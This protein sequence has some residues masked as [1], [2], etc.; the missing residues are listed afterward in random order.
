MFNHVESYPMPKQRRVNDSTQMK[1]EIPYVPGDSVTPRL[2]AAKTAG[3][4]P[5][6][7]VMA[8]DYSIPV[9]AVLTGRRTACAGPSPTCKPAVPLPRG[10]GRRGETYA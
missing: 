3:A 9:R 5:G 1:G 10:Q 4:T 6:L 7:P 8:I 2:P